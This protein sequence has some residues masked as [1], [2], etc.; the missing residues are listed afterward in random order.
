MLKLLPITVLALVAWAALAGA[1]QAK[2]PMQGELS[3]GDL[4]APV[5][6]GEIQEGWIDSYE[7][8]APVAQDNAY[9]LRLWPADQAAPPAGGEWGV[10]KYYPAHDGD[11]AAFQ[12]PDGHFGTVN[13][14]FAQLLDSEISA[15]RAAP[16]AEDGG[17]SFNWWYVPSGLALGLI[18]V[19]G[20]AGLLV[21]RRR[22][23]AV[24]R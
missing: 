16:Q 24:A 10:F 19:G 20:A 8:D 22:H 18:V 14:A 15:N 3:G 17:A 9:T 7:R 5:A 23:A 11:T 2:G 13:G 6:I 4:A 21:S 1:A 12:M